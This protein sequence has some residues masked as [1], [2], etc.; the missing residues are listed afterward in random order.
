MAAPVERGRAAF[1]RQAWRE[2]FAAFSAA[3]AEMPL[4]V[5]DQERLAISAYPPSDVLVIL[6]YEK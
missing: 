6:Q 2:A 3:A 4:D 5:T 1:G